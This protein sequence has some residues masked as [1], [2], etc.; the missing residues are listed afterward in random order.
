MRNAVISIVAGLFLTSLVGCATMQPI[1]VIYTGVT[2]PIAATDNKGPS[3]KVGTSECISI[4]SLFAIGDA[5]INT[6]K[7]AGGITKI[8]SVDWKASNF[9]GIYGSY[10]VTVYGE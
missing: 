1:G 5:S 7:M 4:L 8:H 3:S 6:A 10:T 2:T 9:L